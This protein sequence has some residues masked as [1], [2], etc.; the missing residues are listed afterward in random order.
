MASF[1][2]LLSSRKEAQSPALLTRALNTLLSA[3]LEDSHYRSR[4]VAVMK[5][6]YPRPETKPPAAIRILLMDSNSG[7]RSLR[8]RI[9]ARHGVR[10]TG[11]GDLAEAEAHWGRDLYD[12]VLIDIRRDYRGCLALRDTIKYAMPEQVVAFL[13]GGPRYVDLAPLECSYVAESH[14]SQWADSLRSAIDKSCEDLPLR[15]GLAEANW[16]IVAS[17]KLH[18]KASQPA[19]STSSVTELDVAAGTGTS[20]H[21]TPPEAPGTEAALAPDLEPGSPAPPT[22]L[23]LENK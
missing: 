1:T 3:L 8:S 4:E 17:K 9:L 20:N 18:G 11:T 2:S 12:L 14:G 19:N 22:D 6:A 23:V 7:R 21:T 16:R 13:V 5:S 15:N 10:V